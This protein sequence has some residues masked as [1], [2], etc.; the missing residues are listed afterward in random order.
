MLVYHPEA[1]REFLSNS[2]TQMS[3]YGYSPETIRQLLDLIKTPDGFAYVVALWLFATCVVLVV[4]ASIG[5]AWYSAWLRKR[6][7]H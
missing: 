5:G 2:F 7:G 3:N 4:G 1:L 6:T